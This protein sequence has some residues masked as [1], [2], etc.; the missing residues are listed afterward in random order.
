M[1]SLLD[2]NN[3]LSS[4]GF[5]LRFFNY[6]STFGLG[7]WLSTC[8]TFIYNA[9]FCTF[10][11]KPNCSSSIFF[12]FSLRLVFCKKNFKLDLFYSTHFIFTNRFELQLTL[13]FIN[14]SIIGLKNYKQSWKCSSTITRKEYI[15]K[16]K[17]KQ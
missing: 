5:I 15:L 16:R 17:D 9:K 8:S 12:P 3:N 4:I 10:T 1:I 7:N 6:K 13:I 2:F 11:L 14:I